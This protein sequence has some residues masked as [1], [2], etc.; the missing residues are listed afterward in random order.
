MSGLLSTLRQ[1][2][3]FR[4]RVTIFRQW[5][6][7]RSFPRVMDPPAWD[8]PDGF[9]IKSVGNTG[10]RVIDQ[11][12]STE[13]AQQVIDHHGSLVNRSTVIGQDNASIHHMHRT[14]SDTFISTHADP[15]VGKIVRRAASVL[16][17]P[18]S[19]AENFS[20][21]RYQHGEFYKSHHDHD[22]SL[23]ADR[24]YTVLIYL[25]GLE[26]EEGGGT[27]FPRLNIITQPV[28]GRA[29]IWVNS[30]LDANARMETLHAAMPILREGAEKWVAQLWFRAY[31]MNDKTA[32]VPR[33]NPM[34]GEPLNESQPQLPGVLLADKSGNTWEHASEG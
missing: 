9:T 11:F 2:I 26:A 29:I 10:V 8:Y 34:P 5:L 16:G 27:I 13:E 20:L 31:K 21:T 23:K 3:A 6:S 1:R 25:N 28:C 22:G 33:A 19:H 32:L 7:A 30:D 17:L 14:S 18:P 4:N 12:L 24:L 15:L